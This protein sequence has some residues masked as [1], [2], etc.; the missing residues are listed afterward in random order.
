MLRSTSQNQF[1]K[2]F[3]TEKNN[4]FFLKRECL[5]WINVVKVSLPLRIVQSIPHKMIM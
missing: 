4:L 2:R 3:L 5:M 1:Q